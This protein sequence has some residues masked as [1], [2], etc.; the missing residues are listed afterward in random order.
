M[1]KLGKMDLEKG[2]RVKTKIEQP[3]IM[4]AGRQRVSC[5]KWWSVDKVDEQGYHL[6]DKEGNVEVADQDGRFGDH[7]IYK[8]KKK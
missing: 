5:Y 8:I 4:C 2:Y 1:L 3:H 6:L 7:I